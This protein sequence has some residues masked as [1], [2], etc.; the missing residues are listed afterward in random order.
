MDGIASISLRN[1][2]GIDILVT[3]QNASR[4]ITIQCKTSQKKDKEWILN[5]KPENFFSEN[6]FYVFVNLGD[7]YDRPA[8]HI[9]PSNIVAEHIQYYHHKWLATPGLNNHSH[10]DGPIRKYSDRENEYFER[11]E[12]LGL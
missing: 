5:V 3:N 4:S 11:W 9:V 12:L 2:R 8:Y 7:Q 10:V 1:T 6:H